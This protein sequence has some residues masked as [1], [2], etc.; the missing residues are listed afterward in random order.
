MNNKLMLKLIT[1]V[2]ALTMVIG[3]GLTAYA[4]PGEIILDQEVITCNEGSYNVTVF[5]KAISVA[6]ANTTTIVPNNVSTKIDVMV[7]GKLYV[8]MKK[9]IVHKDDNRDRIVLEKGSYILDAATLSQKQIDKAVKNLIGAEEIPEKMD[10][11]S[12]VYIIGDKGKVLDSNGLEQ[13]TMIRTEA[14]YIPLEKAYAEFAEEMERERERASVAEVSNKTSDSSPSNN[15]EDNSKPVSTVIFYKSTQEGSPAKKAAAESV[16]VR[17]TDDGKL[18]ILGDNAK[19]VFGW[20]YWG[21]VSNLNG[22]YDIA[23]GAGQPGYDKEYELYNDK[24]GAGQ[25][26]YSYLTWSD[27]DGGIEA[28]ISGLGVDLDKL[29]FV[30]YCYSE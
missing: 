4:A 23:D 7:N 30:F 19:A 10:S 8:G 15:S 24:N 13:N 12:F 26:K 22:V 21:D 3:L 6:V 27:I 18:R 2:C 25:D 20:L 5:G 28:D 14:N 9:V 17:I 1:T 29:V 11:R 16:S